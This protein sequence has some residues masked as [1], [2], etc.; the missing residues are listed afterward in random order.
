MPDATAHFGIPECLHLLFNAILK[1][2][3]IKLP[4]RP[5]SSRKHGEG[6]TVTKLH[7]KP[8]RDHTKNPQ[9]KKELPQVM[10]DRAQVTATHTTTAK[11]LQETSP[12]STR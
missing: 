2:I 7:P 6:K 10:K 12:N 5:H 11:N 3:Q 8:R 4:K 1:I 9:C